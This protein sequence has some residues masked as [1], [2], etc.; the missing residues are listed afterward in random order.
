MGGAISIVPKE[1]VFF[2]IICVSS[3]KSQREPQRQ[4]S[5]IA[6][7]FSTGPVLFDGDGVTGAVKWQHRSS[8]E[9]K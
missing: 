5:K 6:L 9:K 7:F 2:I 4:A 3:K 8:T 1:L